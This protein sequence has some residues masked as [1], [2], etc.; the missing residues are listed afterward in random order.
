[1]DDGQRLNDADENDDGALPQGAQQGLMRPSFG[2]PPRSMQGQADDAAQ[3]DA[4][5]GQASPL[6]TRVTPTAGASITTPGSVPA[7]K[8]I[9]STPIKPPGD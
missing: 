5:Q 6:T 9:S 8:T 4:A 7:A 3:T 2:A 1:M